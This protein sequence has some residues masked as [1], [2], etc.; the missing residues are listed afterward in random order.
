MF[1]TSSRPKASTRSACRWAAFDQTN[2]I[3]SRSAC[4][5]T[6]SCTRPLKSI[7]AVTRSGRSTS[8][9][10]FPP[11]EHMISAAA[12]GDELRSM[13]RTRSRLATAIWRSTASRFAGRSTRLRRP[14][15]ASHARVIS[16]GHAFGAHQPG[17]CSQ[18]HRRIGLPG[19]PPTAVSPKKST[20]WSGCLRQ[21][22]PMAIRSSRASAWCCR[23]FWSRRTSCSASSATESARRGFVPSNHRVRAGF[24]AL[25]LPVEQHAGRRT[26]GGRHNWVRFVKRASSRRR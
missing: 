12:I 11:G 22:R 6:A 25:V 13:R 18:D 15:P 23:P 16:C 5:L 19:V 2:P 4:G 14:L 1:A 26:A 8:G 7:P 9:F 3:W 24:A 21:P 17:M 10:P 20:V